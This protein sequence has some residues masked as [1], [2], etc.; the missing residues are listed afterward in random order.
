MIFSAR[1]PHYREPATH[2][3][4]RIYA[5]VVAIEV[6]ACVHRPVLARNKPDF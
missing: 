6:R 3:A 2:D 5:L 1:D 4:L